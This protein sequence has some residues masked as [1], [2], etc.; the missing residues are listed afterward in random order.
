MLEEF[1]PLQVKR[2]GKPGEDTPLEGFSHLT[3][4]WYAARRGVPSVP[5]DA[6]MSLVKD[7]FALL[8]VFCCVGAAPPRSCRTLHAGEKW[9]TIVAFSPDGTLLAAG[10]RGGI[11]RIW[12]T[13]SGKELASFSEFEST[14]SGLAFSPNGKHL[15]AS[16][17]VSKELKIWDVKAKKLSKTVTLPDVIYRICFAPDGKTLAASQEKDVVILRASDFKELHRLKGHTEIVN[18]IAFSADGGTLASG[19]WDQSVRVWKTENGVSK[20]VLTGHKDILQDVIVSQ[21]G[22][23]VASAC[24][25][26]TVRFWDVKRKTEFGTIQSA[27]EGAFSGLA[28]VPEPRPLIV[29]VNA[30]GI[31]RIWDAVSGKN[32]GNVVAGSDLI[33]TVTYCAKTRMLATGGM[34]GTVRLWRLDDFCIKP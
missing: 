22:D 12:D 32:V 16:S 27:E 33:P 4:P 13:A 29:A 19:S 17:C 30:S 26:A 5:E 34:D 21:T 10:F 9:A 23:S 14:I 15:L 25:D 7:W 28:Y 11:V 6:N 8:V 31:L 18:C 3:K 1:T 24:L 2:G 20:G